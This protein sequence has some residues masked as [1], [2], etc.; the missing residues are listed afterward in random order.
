[1]RPVIREYRDTDFREVSDLWEQTGMG[2]PVRGDDAATI[3]KTLQTGGRLL[4]LTLTEGEKIVGTSW[5]T[6]DGR[7]LYL[8]HF[9]IL[10]EYQGRG[11]SGM[12]LQASLDIAR[13]ANMQ[14]KLEVHRTNKRAVEIYKKAGFRYLGDYEVYI[15]RDP[16]QQGIVG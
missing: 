9:G 14:I 1:M 11:W 12:L 10:P 2:G 6:N 7:R 5:L 16:N 15:I 3:Q 4:V 13:S 8:H